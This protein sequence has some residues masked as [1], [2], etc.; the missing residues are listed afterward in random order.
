[1]SDLQLHLVAHF[2]ARARDD[3]APWETADGQV[4]PGEA[5]LDGVALCL[6]SPDDLEREQAHRAIGSSVVDRVGL[7]IS[8]Y[9]V[10]AYVG[11]RDRTFRDTAVGNID[12]IEGRH[13]K[14]AR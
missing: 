14:E 11:A 5:R 8:L 9:T 6:K 1:M 2:E 3:L 10:T 13:T 12:L 4:L 7:A